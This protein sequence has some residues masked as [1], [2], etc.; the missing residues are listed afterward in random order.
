MAKIT[1]LFV[2]AI[3]LFKFETSYCVVLQESNQHRKGTQENTDLASQKFTVIFHLAQLY[4]TADPFSDE[5]TVNLTIGDQLEL[6]DERIYKEGN[7]WKNNWSTEWF[8]FK[9][10]KLA[11]KQNNITLP[12]LYSYDENRL[13]KSGFMPKWHCERYLKELAL[14]NNNKSAF[15]QKSLPVRAEFIIEKNSLQAF[16]N[17]NAV[18]NNNHNLLLP[19]GTELILN[20][21]FAKHDGT[22]YCRLGITKYS[23]DA[24]RIPESFNYLYIEQDILIKN[25][26]K[27]GLQDYSPDWN[28]V[29][30]VNY[31]IL[32]NSI[33]F[34][35]NNEHEIKENILQREYRLLTGDIIVLH[36][37]YKTFKNKKCRKFTLLHSSNRDNLDNSKEDQGLTVSNSIKPGVSGWIINKLELLGDLKRTH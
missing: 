11:K 18:E 3:S 34:I 36:E 32:N 35:V 29:S 2:I 6:L 16:R 17:F 26:R 23:N 31:K 5:N 7:K 27:I 30:G 4:P 1:Y 14:N 37:E 9:I 25:S 33:I 21:G 13:G 24:S 10:I 15:P 12:F 28:I 19:I 20:N 22:E 8:K